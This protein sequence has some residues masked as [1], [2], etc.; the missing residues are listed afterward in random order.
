MEV[1]SR[2]VVGGKRRSVGRRNELLK[3]RLF[4]PTK[5]KTK[6][7]AEPFASDPLSFEAGSRKTTARTCLEIPFWELSDMW[8]LLDVDGDNVK[9]G[10][11]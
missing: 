6:P 11:M 7:P 8:L 5:T 3:Y 10:A 4:T 9:T 1:L 2:L